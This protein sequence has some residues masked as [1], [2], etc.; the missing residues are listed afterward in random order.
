VRDGVKRFATTSPGEHREKE[1]ER[2]G[3]GKERRCASGC[4]AKVLLKIVATIRD[5]I[6]DSFRS[7][8]LT[9]TTR[10]IYVATIVQLFRHDSTTFHSNLSVLQQNG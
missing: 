3:G 5:H 9:F 8:R 1:R 7:Q 10:R 6:V 2:E 4:T